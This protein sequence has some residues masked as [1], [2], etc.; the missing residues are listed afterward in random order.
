MT[1]DERHLF[2]IGHSNHPLEKFIELLRRHGVEVVVDTRS[3]PY[4]RHAPHFNRDALRTALAGAGIRYSFLGEELGGRPRGE[5]YYDAEGHVRYD[6]V[7]GAD[8]FQSGIARV[9]RGAAKYRLA[10][11]CAEENPEGCHRRLLIARVLSAHGFTVDHIRGDG[12]LEREREFSP[13]GGERAPVQGTLFDVPEER[14]WRS[15]RS[16]LPRRALPSSSKPS[17]VPASDG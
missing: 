3:Q 14:P 15:I 9:K 4:S 12:R 1:P 2:T 6:R 16:V 13:A 7:A 10:L 17:N 11:L 8:F 5:E